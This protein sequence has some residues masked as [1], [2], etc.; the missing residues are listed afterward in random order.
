[1]T[2]DFGNSVT[3]T[4][5]KTKDLNDKSSNE[6]HGFYKHVSKVFFYRLFYVSTYLCSLLFIVTIGFSLNFPFQ[7]NY[8]I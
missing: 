7:Q 5:E 3:K 6:F 8:R 1:M 4:D 2:A